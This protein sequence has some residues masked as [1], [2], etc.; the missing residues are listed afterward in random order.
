M[1][2]TIS[3]G[4]QK[5]INVNSRIV[6]CD[7]YI[8]SEYKDARLTVVKIE[9]EG[10]GFMPYVQLDQISAIEPKIIKAVFE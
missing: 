9:N 10:L 3:D 1:I 5:D 8:P 6:I 4:S 2:F 7:D